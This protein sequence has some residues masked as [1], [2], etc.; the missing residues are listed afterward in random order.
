MS[1][2]ETKNAQGHT[3][4]QQS[5]RQET[6]QPSGDMQTWGQRR[7]GGGL[8]RTSSFSLS[9]HEIFT[10]SP[11][12]LMR[13]FAEQ[14]D[15]AFE[16]FGLSSISTSRSQGSFPSEIT[17]W[18]PAIE[19]FQRE[20]G[21]VVRA[22]LPGLNKE[23]VKVEITDDGLILQGERKQEREENR[24]GFYRSERTYGRFY[25]VIPLP[26][27]IDPEQVR[28]GFNNGVLEIELPVTQSKQRRREVPIGADGGEQSRA[29]SAKQS[30]R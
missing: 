18:S 14:M 12:E 19:I 29:A 20:G 10:A 17:R 9:P 24:E 28:A 30:Q 26:D 27:G 23:D 16:D 22:E 11:F 8:A 21:L 13:R 1:R 6:G 3:N 25:R 5:K 2:S 4:E 15:R 7:Q